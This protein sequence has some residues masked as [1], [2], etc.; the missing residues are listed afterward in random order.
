M[1][2]PVIL[3]HLGDAYRSL[4]SFGKALAAYERSRDLQ[5]DNSEI[6][7]KIDAARKQLGN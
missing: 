3:E 6:L 5:G 4:K 7:D 1:L 2:D